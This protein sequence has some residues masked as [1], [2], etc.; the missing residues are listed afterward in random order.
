MASPVAV[1]EP[2]IVC[3]VPDVKL[4]VGLLVLSIV[5]LLKVVVPETVCVVPVKETVPLLWVKVPELEKLPA[6]LNVPDVEVNVPDAA[7]VK[8]PVEVMV[9]L[10]VAPV[11]ETALL[12]SPTVTVPF[13]VTVPEAKVYVGEPDAGINATLL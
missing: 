2:L 12:P 1:K 10:L 8:F 13:A 11:T 7:T 6:T 5:K 3:V 4:I 9:G